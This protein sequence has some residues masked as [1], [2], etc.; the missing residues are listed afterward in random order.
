MARVPSARYPCVRSPSAPT[1]TR[2]TLPLARPPLTP[3]RHHSPPKHQALAQSLSAPFWGYLADNVSRRNLLSTGCILVSIATL[4]VSQSESIGEIA[5]FRGLAGV[6]LAIVGPIAQSLIADLVVPAKRGFA[7]GLLGVT[8][9]IG[10]MGGTIFAGS[11]SKKV[12][13]WQLGRI[14]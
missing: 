3:Y 9:G 13:L 12:R 4:S 8:A 1:N 11:M 6:G 10:S 5:M 2:P 14:D 7:F